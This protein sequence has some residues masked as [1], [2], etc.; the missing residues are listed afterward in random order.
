MYKENLC[1]IVLMQGLIHSFVRMHLSRFLCP[2]SFSK[3]SMQVLVH[4]APV[5]FL[6]CENL[7]KINLILIVRIVHKHF[8]QIEKQAPTI[9]RAGMFMRSM[10][11][12]K[13]WCL[14]RCMLALRAGFIASR[15]P[16]T[17]ETVLGGEWSVIMDDLE[18]ETG[19]EKNREDMKTFE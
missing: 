10:Q 15:Q 18:S 7:T 8:L 5:L 12:Q 4:E 2:Q 3:K 6:F 14:L 19:D 17:H 11:A 16:Q 1:E 9:Y 13:P